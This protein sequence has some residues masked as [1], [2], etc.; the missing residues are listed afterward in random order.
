MAALD[1][2]T[3]LILTVGAVA[4]AAYASYRLLKPIENTVAGVGEGTASL[5]QGSSKGLTSAIIPTGQA[6]GQ[7][8]TSAGNLASDV[9]NIPKNYWNLIFGIGESAGQTVRGWFT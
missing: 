1:S 5:V 4:I 2:D 3:K 8:A 7:V 6:V 9:L